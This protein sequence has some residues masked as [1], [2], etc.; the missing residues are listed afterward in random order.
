MG[1]IDGCVWTMVPKCYLPCRLLADRHY[2]R[3]TPGHPLF[4]RPGY[5]QVLYYKDP[6]GEAAWVWFRP[7]WES[8]IKGTQR[9]DKLL[10]IECTLFRNE[11]SAKSSELILEACFAL[12]SWEHAI[13]V[14]WPDGAITGIK[15]SA[16]T[17]GRSKS[18]LPGQCYRVAGW[19]PLEHN[20]SAKADVWLT[21]PREWFAI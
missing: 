16:T 3:Q 10:S 15:S 4:T 13:D 21:Y 7:K 11:T 17:R 6:K 19:I 2:S 18:S 20:S 5:N 14:A 8:G 9:K 12:Q 1:H